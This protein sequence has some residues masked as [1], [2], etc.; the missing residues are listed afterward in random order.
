MWRYAIG[1]VVLASL[2]VPAFAQQKEQYEAEDRQK[3][4]DDAALDQQYRSA[5]QRMQQQKQQ[6][7]GTSARDP[8]ANM[9]AN[10]QPKR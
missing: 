9:R 6:Q 3:K 10:E 2:S 7:Q 8:W 4:R 1:I 5:L